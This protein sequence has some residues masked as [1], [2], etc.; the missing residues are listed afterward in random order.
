MTA[1]IQ[2]SQLAA[3]NLG[4]KVSTTG[5]TV[6]QN[7]NSALFTV[8]GGRVV[9]LGIV[10][11]VTTVIGG[12][13]PSAKLV[14]NPTTGTDSDITSAVAITSDPVGN[15]YGV[16]TVGGALVVL[17]SVA[18]LNQTPFVVKAGTIDLNVSAADATGA[19]KWDLFY[20]PLDPGASVT[21]A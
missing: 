11:E 17:E 12:T 19:I 3:I 2:G 16:A 9:V 4:A 1:M 14:A 7:A 13:T 10:G 5:K 15:L 20:V 21:A 8:S 6:P 18:P